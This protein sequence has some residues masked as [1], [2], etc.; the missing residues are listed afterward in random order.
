V[1]KLG[2]AFISAVRASAKKW[3]YEESLK[4]VR[5]VPT[6]LEDDSIACGAA[7]LVMQQV[8]ARI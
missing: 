7:A 5:I 6:S 1:E 3:A 8:F 4:I 2:E